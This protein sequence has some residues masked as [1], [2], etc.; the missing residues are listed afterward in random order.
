MASASRGRGRGNGTDQRDGAQQSSGGITFVRFSIIY[1]DS[2]VLR[3]LN[4]K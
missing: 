4:N 3:G 1:K 2:E